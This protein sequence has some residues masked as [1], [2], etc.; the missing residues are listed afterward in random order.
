MLQQKRKQTVT[1]V[2]NVGFDRLNW[3]LIFQLHHSLYFMSGLYQA[4]IGY[5]LSTITVSS[6]SNFGLNILH[7]IYMPWADFNIL[8]AWR[9]FR[10]HRN[11]AVR[12]SDVRSKAP[13]IHSSADMRF[14][15]CIVC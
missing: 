10:M 8:E 2:K 13:V 9:F 11:T 5:C 12:T 3:D 14:T 1:A 6:V 7:V 15:I 4:L